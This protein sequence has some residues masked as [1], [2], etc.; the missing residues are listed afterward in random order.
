MERKRLIEELDCKNKTIKQM[1]SALE[2]M[3]IQDDYCE[4]EIGFRVSIDGAY[5]SLTHNTL[6]GYLDMFQIAQN[7]PR[8]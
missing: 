3:Y 2:E 5:G 6:K 1:E 4:V 8:A 7:Q